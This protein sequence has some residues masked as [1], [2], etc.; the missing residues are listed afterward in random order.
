MP[1]H[2]KTTP[3]HLIHIHNNHKTILSLKAVIHQWTVQQYLKIS[4]VTK[5]TIIFRSYDVSFLYMIGD[6]NNKE[7]EKSIQF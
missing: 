6:N 1:L 2:N 5:I 7:K 4:S 3:I